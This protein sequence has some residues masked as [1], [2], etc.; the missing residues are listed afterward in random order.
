MKHPR[1]PMTVYSVPFVT[2]VA[3]PLPT[4]GAWAAQGHAI[5]KEI[6]ARRDVAYTTIMTTCVRLAEKDSCAGKR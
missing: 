6:V 3:A 4:P 5:H 2:I 1:T